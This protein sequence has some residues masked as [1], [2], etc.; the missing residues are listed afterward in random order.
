MFKKTLQTSGQDGGVGKHGHLFVQPQQK[1]QLDY[2]AAFIQMGRRGRDLRRH[3]ERRRDVEGAVPHPCVVGKNQGD[4]LGAQDP[5]HTPDHSALGS[6][7]GYATK[8]GSHSS[9][10]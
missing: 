10:T 3:S 9:S 8:T 6:T 5:S 7:I 2:K 1:P 4:A